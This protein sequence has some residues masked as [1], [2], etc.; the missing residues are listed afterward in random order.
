MWPT[1]VDGEPWWD[2][3]W[4]IMAISAA[5][6]T[7]NQDRA[8]L[9]PPT[10]N[11]MDGARGGIAAGLAMVR[12]HTSRR[13]RRGN[14]EELESFKRHGHSTPL[15]L[16]HL[17]FRRFNPPIPGAYRE[18]HD[19]RHPRTPMA[20]ESPQRGRLL[21]G[22]ARLHHKRYITLGRRSNGGIFYRRLRNDRPQ[23]GTPADG[24]STR[25]PFNGWG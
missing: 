3:T 4:P 2:K 9:A 5:P 13:A 18:T 21:S 7:T 10:T 14:G 20:L 1:P 17:R 8:L 15:H 12:S 25:D 16:L 22:L 11:E 24:A 23:H 6:A 19:R